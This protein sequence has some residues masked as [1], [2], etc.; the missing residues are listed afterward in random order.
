MISDRDRLPQ[1]WNEGGQ[2]RGLA[3]MMMTTTTTGNKRRTLT[4]SLVGKIS[5]SHHR[6]H[7]EFFSKHYLIMT[8]CKMHDSYWFNNQSCKPPLG[9]G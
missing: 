3:G 2:Q 8:I 5:S 7:T 4:T 6:G 9:G 1:S